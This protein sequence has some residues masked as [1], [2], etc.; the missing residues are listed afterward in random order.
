MII[1]YKGKTAQADLQTALNLLQQNNRRNK[2]SKGNST[3]TPSPNPQLLESHRNGI[4]TLGKLR[5][6]LK[7]NY[8]KIHFMNQCQVLLVNFSVF[9][10]RKIDA[11]YEKLF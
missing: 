10:G 11:H 9:C 8:Q 3:G 6:S 5:K 2:S 7:S 4:R 1:Q